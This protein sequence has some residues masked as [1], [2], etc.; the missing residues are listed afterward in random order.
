MHFCWNFMQYNLY[1]RNGLIDMRLAPFLSFVFFFSGFASL[2][3]QVGWQRLLTLYYGVGPISTTIIVSVY[4]LGLG[5]GYLLGG[6]LVERVANRTILYFAIE[7]CAGLFR[8][9]ELAHH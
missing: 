4:M 9:G 5:V 7:L 1:K 3:Y 8:I 6:I 2:I